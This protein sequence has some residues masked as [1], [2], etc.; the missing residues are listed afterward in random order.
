LVKAQ[1]WQRIEKMAQQVIT[2]SVD[3]VDGD[4]EIAWAAD[5]YA[6]HKPIRQLLVRTRKQDGTWSFSLLVCNAPD[7]LLAQLGHTPIRRDRREVDRMLAML[8]AYDRRGGGAETQFKA[9]KQGLFLAKRNKQS[10]AAQEMLVLLAQLAHNL[11]I[12]TRNA[13]PDTQP[14]FH[15]LGIL[16]LVRDVLTIPGKIELDSQ[17]RMLAIILNQRCPY[18]AALVDAFSDALATDGLVLD[19]G[20]I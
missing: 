1:G 18:A 17:G 19:I 16:R 14:V 6:Y 5:P 13:L 2:W 15:R 20:E 4:R 7:I 12:W 9:D 8:Y 10:F 11:L 3:P